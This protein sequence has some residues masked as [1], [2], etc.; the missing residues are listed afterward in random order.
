ML[1][2]HPYPSTQPTHER[3]LDEVLRESSVVADRERLSRIR[4]LLSYACRLHSR[5]G[6]TSEGEAALKRFAR[7]YLAGRIPSFG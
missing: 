3:I 2:L 4:L 5:T 7:L 6:L 1:D